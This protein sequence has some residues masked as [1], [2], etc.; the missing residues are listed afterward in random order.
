MGIR[1]TQRR[2]HYV[3]GEAAAVLRPDP[4][5]TNLVEIDPTNHAEAV[6]SDLHA[7][8]AIA[9]FA[10]ER[11]RA[12]DASGRRGSRS[13]I[14][15]MLTL[16][17]QLQAETRRAHDALE[18]GRSSLEAQLSEGRAAATAL[19]A[20][21][22]LK[23]SALSHVET[24]LRTAR[25]SEQA[26]RAEIGSLREEIRSLSDAA[27]EWQ[28]MRD[29]Q[30]HERVLLRD[31]R[32]ARLREH[33]QA[34]AAFEQE[35]AR[36]RSEARSETQAARAMRVQAAALR[37]END[38][39]A[40]SVARLRQEVVQATERS[41]RDVG[42]AAEPPQQD[43]REVGDAEVGRLHRRI[44]ELRAELDALRPL[45]RELMEAADETWRARAVAAK[46]AADLAAT[47]THLADTQRRLDLAEGLVGIIRGRAGHV[48]RLLGFRRL[49]TPLAR[50]DA[51]LS[52]LGVV[53]RPDVERDRQRHLLEASGLFDRDFYLRNNPDVVAHAVDPLDHYLLHGG[54]EGRQAGPHF[55]SATYLR[56]HPDVA[57]AGDNPLVHY[58]MFG[59]GEGR[60][61][62]R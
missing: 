43:I 54:R 31:E 50:Y 19:R 24:E 36:L 34:S 53:S 60:S 3:A 2:I 7:N 29:G 35:V 61:I 5:V 48:A 25:R 26:D 62:R 40:E 41:G 16:V 13:E 56:L 17:A 28:R 57:A 38:I 37:T 10:E 45:D 55:D 59:A 39:L 18:H 30:E 32:D 12:V 52:A 44:A 4:T 51:A 27:A 1:E 47:M 6:L 58:V 14:E 9:A 46:S 33:A 23:R 22:E 21:L 8:G 49:T 20:E 15:L 42:P 11:L